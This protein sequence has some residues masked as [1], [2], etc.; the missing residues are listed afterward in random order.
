MLYEYAVDPEITRREVAELK[1]LFSLFGLDRGRYISLFPKKQWF[2][3][4]YKAAASQEPVAKKRIEE[5]LV[6]AKASKAFASG[7]VPDPALNW[8]GN[9][10]ASHV[11]RPFQA[12]VS[13]E[14]DPT[15]PAIIDFNLVDEAHALF[16]CDQTC[17]VERTEKALVSALLPMALIGKRLALIDP[18]LDLRNPGGQ[19][20]RSLIARL[21]TELAAIG[22]A[23]VVLELHW[24]SHD[25]RPPE[26]FVLANAG[27]W[28]EGLI[29]PGFKL[30]LHEWGE[31]AGGED[32]HDRF[33][34]T[35]AGGISAGAG[36]EVVGS[37]EK[38]QLSLLAPANAQSH[39]N[40]LHPT[41]GAFDLVFR[42]VVVESDGRTYS[43]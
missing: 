14:T 32:F 28:S 35:D 10:R 11:E 15:V 17:R 37:H 22:K 1:H 31:R 9:T 6:R 5:L 36:F 4:A 2:S 34:L 27:A 19:D 30:M 13:D 21:L 7:R 23:N 3:E 24:R 43:V 26:A 8:M 25:R 16:E 18:F 12:I 33:F 42:P 20:F 40:D 29:P 38:V 41:N 39:W